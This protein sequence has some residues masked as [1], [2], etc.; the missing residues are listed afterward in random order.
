VAYDRVA[1]VV[2]T[3]NEDGAHHVI[4]EVAGALA[5]APLGPPPS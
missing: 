3:G 5:A 1:G 4:S 2:V